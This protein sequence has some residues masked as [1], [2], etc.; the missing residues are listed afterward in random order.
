MHVVSR[1]RIA[2]VGLTAAALVVPLAGPASAT[3]AGS[4]RSGT[5]LA[6]PAAV[7]YGANLHLQGIVG[8]AGT[9]V[10]IPGAR[11]V[12]QRATP[13]AANW[14]SVTSTVTNA[15]GR[16]GFYPAAGRPFAY[17]V[18]WP[19]NAT[20]AASVSPVRT[21]AVRPYVTISSMS[22]T[23]P[24]GE[25]DELTAD[26]RVYPAVQAARPV[27]LQRYDA[28]TNSFRNIAFGT[29]L[30]EYI[31]FTAHVGGSTAFYRVYAPAFG[32]YAAG[33]SAARPFTHFS[34]RGTFARPLRG[35]GGT[36]QPHFTVFP[37]DRAPYRNIAG[38]YAGRGGSV[39]ADIDVAGCNWVQINRVDGVTG[40]G[41][42][43]RVELLVDGKVRYSAD[44]TGP[45]SYPEYPYP[46]VGVSGRSTLRL[47]ISD[48]DT[49][50]GPRAVVRMTSY[51]AR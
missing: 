42:R 1:L 43:T 51:C 10:R 22:D 20:Y 21:P 26:V 15:E 30:A 50:T 40:T 44:V 3:A 13:G 14:T 32:G 34:G 2:G 7:T 8:R 5:S 31:S 29:T 16:Y 49:S 48:V 19:G 28:R 17:R 9:A 11:V 12:L 39:W 37:P 23:Y 24:Y 38:G 45:E 41:G 25:D 46:E 47:R 35:T 4:V 33:Y 6:A 27:F 18:V 36:N